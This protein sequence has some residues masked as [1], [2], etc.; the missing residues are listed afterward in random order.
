MRRLLPAVAALCLGCPPA[1]VEVLHEDRPADYSAFWPAEQCKNCHERIVTQHAFSAHAAAYSNP[2]FQAQLYD[3]LLP[4]IAAEPGLEKEA[5]SCLAC[6]SPIAYLQNGGR[7][8]EPSEVHPGFQGVTCDFCH[9][10]RGYR[11][12][13]PGNANYISVPGETKLGPLRISGNWHHAYSELISKSEF[14]AICH[15]TQNTHGLKLRTTY[16]EWKASSYAKRGIQCQ[17]CHMSA[18][19]MLVDGKPQ[20]EKGPIARLTGGRTP[21]PE[22]DHLH[23][24]RFPGAHTVQQLVG[25]L[26]LKVVPLPRPLKPGERI[27]IAI[28]VENTHVGHKVPSGSVELRVFWLEVRVALSDEDEGV[29]LR[30]RPGA[31][32]RPPLDVAGASELEQALLR[33]DVPEGSRVYRAVVADAAGRPTLLN[34]EGRSILFDNRLGAAE[35][36][37][38]VYDYVVPDH[39]EDD[40]DLHVT[41]TLKY[42]RYPT[43]FADGLEVDHAEVVT[44]GQG[45]GL[46]G[47]VPEYDQR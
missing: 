43:L 13:V 25:A 42:L 10:I 1:A 19:G 27:E 47:A 7:I 31:P 4:R 21:P 41:A 32:G 29:L 3:Q 20:F 23:S 30:A 38:E 11:G 16:E 26:T 9:T 28:D 40:N 2:I 44:I 39:L 34:Y 18:R 6:H 8:V 37:R 22:R 46:V 14:C 35:T 33:G 15:S 45:S 36:R 12:D 17:D 24:H 5:R